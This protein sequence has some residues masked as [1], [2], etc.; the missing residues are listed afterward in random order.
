MTICTIMA[1]TIEPQIEKT[2]I[3]EP[4]LGIPVGE[5]FPSAALEKEIYICRLCFSIYPLECFCNTAFDKL[6]WSSREKDGKRGSG[7][8]PVL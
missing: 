6:S 5:L 7:H 1:F 2:Q 8:V 3:Q 4:V